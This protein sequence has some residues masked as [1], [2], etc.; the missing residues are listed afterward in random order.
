[1]IQTRKTAAALVAGLIGAIGLSASA[2]AACKHEV[3]VLSERGERVKVTQVQV[4]KNVTPPR[5][6]TVKLVDPRGIDKKK[7]KFEDEVKDNDD[8]VRVAPA[9]KPVRTVS[10]QHGLGSD[11]VL[12]L[13]ESFRHGFRGKTKKTTSVEI[14]AMYDVLTRQGWRGPFQA[15]TKRWKPCGVGVR[16]I[17]LR[18]SDR[19]PNR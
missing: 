17:V 11:R 10:S 16:K 7:G 5:I 6:T 15:V 2:Q 1:M 13:G 3:H 19:A 9:P 4:F 18:K 14:V 8:H 12:H